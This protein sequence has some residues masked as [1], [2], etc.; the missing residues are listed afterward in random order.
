M[1]NGQIAGEFGELHPDVSADRKFKQEV[2]LA[3]LDLDRLF[4]IPLREPRYERLSRFPA[5]ERD[6][7]VLLDDSASY[8]SLRSAIEAL[9]IPELRSI[10][11]R[12]LFRG[13]TVPG[14]KYA[15]LLRLTF[16]SAERTLVD[17]EIAAWSKRAVAAV[18]ALGGSLRA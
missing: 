16:Q 12:E 14:G 8:R 4:A 17:E 10:E 9:R 1:L 15:L 2:W 7:S 3:Q 13:G 11:P 5:V 6:F 18:E